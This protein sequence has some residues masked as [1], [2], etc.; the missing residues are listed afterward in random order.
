MLGKLSNAGNG[1][2]IRLY[3]GRNYDLGLLSEQILG[4]L[5]QEYTLGYYPTA[6]PEHDVLRN[7][8]VHVAKP[9]ARILNARLFLQRRDLN[10]AP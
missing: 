5:H 3:T 4:E 10:P 2:V 7:I 9:G 6:G 8:E 1:R